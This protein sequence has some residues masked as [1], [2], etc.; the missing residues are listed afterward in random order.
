MAIDYLPVINTHF[1]LFGGHQETVPADWQWPAEEHPAFELMYILKGRQ[2]TITETGELVLQAGEFTVIPIETRHTNY[3]LDHRPMTYFC[4]HFNLDDPALRYLLI[5]EYAG[6]V[7]T[8]ADAIYPALRTQAEHLMAMIGPDYNLADQ[9]D[10]QVSVIDVIMTLVKDLKVAGKFK[11]H[12][13]DV[14]QFM[15][16]HQLA[17]DLKAQLDYQIYHAAEP[18]QTSVAKIVAARNISQSYALKLFQKYYHESPQQYLIALK[19]ATAKELLCQPKARINAVSAKLAYAS[20][21]HFT[22]EFK[23]HFGQTPRAYMRQEK[24]E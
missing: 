10:L 7:I 18:Q 22:R 9:L 11:P 8:P 21:S 4:M 14:D 17:S 6:R 23:K 3:A 12:A 2:R 19:L 24:L 15:L 20:P 16:C 5:R 13:A 1:T